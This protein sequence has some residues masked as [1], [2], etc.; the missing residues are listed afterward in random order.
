M[1]KLSLFISVFLLILLTKGSLLAQVYTDIPGSLN[2]INF[3]AY[4]V[5]CP[6]NDE[7]DQ[8]QLLLTVTNTTNQTMEV[9][10]KSEIWI[11]GSCAN[12][13]VLQEYTHELVILPNSTLQAQCFDNI[14]RD[15]VYFIRFDDVETNITEATTAIYFRELMVND[16]N[17]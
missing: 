14:N 9:S 11:N 3:N 13:G 5:F 17:N 2:G 10:W 7:F 16:Y 12:C 8:E 1:K 4:E 6:S 15:L